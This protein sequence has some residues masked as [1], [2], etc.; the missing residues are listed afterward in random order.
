MLGFSPPSMSVWIKHGSQI[1]KSRKLHNSL[2]TVWDLSPKVRK[3]V[4]PVMLER[5]PLGLQEVPCYI[6]WPCADASTA[7][8]VYA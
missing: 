4:P 6:R 7:L 5:I 8:N 3:L 1:R 2:K